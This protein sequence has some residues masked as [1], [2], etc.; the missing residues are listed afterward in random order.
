MGSKTRIKKIEKIDGQRSTVHIVLSADGT[1]LT[2]IF[3][4]KP[5]TVDRVAMAFLSEIGLTIRKTPTGYSY[6]SVIR[7]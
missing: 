2:F 7:V 3:K 4:V 1:I 6:A 5:E